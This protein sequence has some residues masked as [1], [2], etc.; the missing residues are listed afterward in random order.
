MQALALLRHRRFSQTINQTLF[1][2]SLSVYQTPYTCFNFLNTH[3]IDK[4][5]K[6]SLDPEGPKCLSSRIEKLP[7]GESV[8]YA[9]Q[10]WMGEGFPIHRGD[11]FHTINRLRKLRLNKRALEVMEWVVRERPYR[12]KE[13]DY[14]YL[15]EFTTKHH[16]ISHGEKL[17]LHVPS[18]FQNELLYNNLVISCLEKG[19]IR[20]SLDYM[21]KM[22]EQGHPISYLIFNRLI[23]LH[24]SP[25][26][27]K[28]IPKIL[29]QMRADKVVPHVST[30]NIL[31]KIEA[32]EHNIDG[33]VKV[34]NDMKRFKVEPNEVSF[35]ILATA[36]AAARLYTVAEAYVEAVEKSC[37]GDNWSTLDV[38]IILYGHLGKE[39]ELERTWGIVLELPHVRSKSYMVAIEAY[40]K[41]GQ[42]SRAEELWLEMKSIHGLRSTEQFNSMLSVYCKHGLIKKATGNF[43]EMEINGCKA[44]SITFRHLALGCLKA[45]LVEEA[46]KTLE[47]GKN[48][49]TS[50]RVKNSTP[51]LE[52][53]LSIIELFAE[54]GDVVNVEKLFE[55]LAKAKYTRHTFVFNIL[56]KAYVKAKIYSPNL[57]RRMILG[58]ARPDA[59]TYSLIKLA[60]QFRP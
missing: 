24:S 8:G 51:W 40:G 23:I 18:E 2:P 43:R 58:G 6:K 46:L 5:P 11:V 48:L 49:T 33:L 25:G 15:L 16:G 37:S 34:F 53:T 39:K 47:M 9:F 14:S 10:S 55:E 21:K 27:R 26:S 59:E 52:T 7:R 13:L 57:L 50:N 28:M 36:H 54:K 17:F 19:V 20:L 30:Y 32:N 41:I 1:I 44:N 42:L 4:F 3:T 60:E 29:A 31:M 56:I 38:L 35:C 22:R 12:L 45:N